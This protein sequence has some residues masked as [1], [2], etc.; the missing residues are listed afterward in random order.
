MIVVILNP[1]KL[2]AIAECTTHESPQKYKHFESQ[3]LSCPVT[4]GVG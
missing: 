3:V 1:V 2:N 4:V